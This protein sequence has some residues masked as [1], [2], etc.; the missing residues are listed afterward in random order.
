MNRMKFRPAWKRDSKRF[1]TTMSDPT[2]P[3]PPN[4]RGHQRKGS[5]YRRKEVVVHCP[6][7]KD[8]QATQHPLRGDLEATT[9]TSEVPAENS[10]DTAPQPVKPPV[11]IASK[12]Q[13]DEPK[14]KE[15]HFTIFYDDTGYSYESIIGPYL[16][17]VKAVTIEDPYIRLKRQIHNFVR[18][19]EAV[20]KQPTIRNIAL[21][22][23]YD[24]KTPMGE[25]NEQLG[26]LQQSL[27]EM[28]VVLSI[29]IDENIHDREICLDNGWVIKIGRGLDFFQ[30]PDSWFG[31][32][33]NDFSQRKCLKTKVDIFK[34]EESK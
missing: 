34:V 26:E 10:K 33:V 5:L 12:S 1:R 14:L 3:T 22:T 16:K 28:D 32:G 4:P 11:P 6:E 21:T 9:S 20:V 8:A 19:C 31:I 23:G 25:L 29:N 17:G 18:F 24:E 30:K 15:Q 27:L 7:S 13:G 2:R